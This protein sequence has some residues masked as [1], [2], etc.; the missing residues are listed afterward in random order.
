MKKAIYSVITGD[1]NI[2]HSAPN[3]KGWD[4]IMFTD[5]D[6]ESRGW[7]IE[8]IECNDPLIASRDFKIRSHIYL[9]EY[10]LV[11]YID[12]NQVMIKEPIE[13][14]WFMHPRRTNIFEESKQIINLKKADVKE[15]LNQIEYYTEM[16]YEDC[17]LYLNGFFIREHR[18]D[19]NEL[20]DVWFEETC[21][22]T[23]R[24][25]LSLPYAIWLTGITPKNIHKT[26]VKE[27]YA[28]INNENTS[29]YSGRLR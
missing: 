2:Y 3:F 8:H 19:I 16:G 24:D 4:K 14:M 9:K 13:P 26:L 20:H 7:E 18:E 6:I 10:D 15:T 1:Y 12:A 29:H 25:Q 28:Y 27:R 22:F 5:K 17:G 23:Q 21:R 11:C